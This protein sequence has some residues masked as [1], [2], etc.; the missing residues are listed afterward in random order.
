MIGESCA[1]RKVKGGR[2][3]SPFRLR[4]KSHGGQC[5]GHASDGCRKL[6]VVCLELAQQLAKSAGRRFDR[7]RNRLIVRIRVGFKLG[8][9]PVESLERFL[10][11]VIRTG[12]VPAKLLK[13]GK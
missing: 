13:G 7:V 3:P 12:E 8:D 1:F 6:G 10:V 2:L 11:N 9:Q 5:V 4:S